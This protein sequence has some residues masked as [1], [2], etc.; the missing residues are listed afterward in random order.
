MLNEKPLKLKTYSKLCF[1]NSCPK[2]FQ[3]FK[4]HSLSWKNDVKNVCKKQFKYNA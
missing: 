4:K 1:K 2:H 3:Y